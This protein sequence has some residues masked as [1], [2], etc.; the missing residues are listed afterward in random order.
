MQHAIMS[1]QGHLPPHGAPLL[2]L[3]LIAGLGQSLSVSSTAKLPF[4]ASSAFD[5]FEDL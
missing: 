2:V 4:S 5:S 3:T 1:Y